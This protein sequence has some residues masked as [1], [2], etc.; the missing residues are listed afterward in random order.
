M[1]GKKNV[2]DCDGQR[3]GKPGGQGHGEGEPGGQG[4]GSGVSETRDPAATRGAR[5]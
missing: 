2:A 1:T 4:K 3:R 5:H